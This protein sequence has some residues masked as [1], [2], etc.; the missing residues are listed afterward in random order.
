MVLLSAMLEF[1]LYESVP[2]RGGLH[3]LEHTAELELIQ[4]AGSERF[5]QDF[6]GVIQEAVVMSEREKRGVYGV[7]LLPVRESLRKHENN[8]INKNKINSTMH[9]GCIKHKMN[10]S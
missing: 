5:G 2:V 9:K 6:S 1:F 7:Y 4:R 8:K 3:S 10:L